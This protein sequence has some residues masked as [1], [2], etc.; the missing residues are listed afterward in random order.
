MIIGTAGHIDHGKTSLVHVLTGVDTDRLKQEKAQGISIELGYAYMPASAGQTIGFID[1]PGHERL[2]HTMAA[3]SSGIDF[4]LLVVAADDGVMP[5]TRE[6]VAILK[7]L[8]VRDGAV[9]ITKRDR[10]DLSRASAVRR[11]VA[12]LVSGTFLEGKPVFE[13]SAVDASHPGIQALRDYLDARVDACLRR[14][15]CGLFRLAIDRVF[16]LQGHGTV[17]TGTVYS[18]S[19]A[20]G[21]ESADLRLM[22]SGQRIRIRS[23]RAQ[24]REVSAATMGQRCALNLPGISTQN[25]ARGDWIADARCFTPSRNVDVRLEVLET[26]DMPIRTWTAV[27]VHLGAAHHVA[28][29]VPLM[30]GA[31]LPRQSAVVQL[32]FQDPVCAMPGDRFIV[33]NAQARQTIAGG[34]VLD[35]NAPDRKR[36]SPAR[37]AWLDG[38]WTLLDRGDWSPLL[39]QA[40]HGLNRALL[41]RLADGAVDYGGPDDALWVGDKEAGRGSTLILRRHWNVLADSVSSALDAYH[42]AATDEPGVD[43][44]RLKRM[45]QPRLANDV[46]TALLDDLIDE[47][48]IVR[49]GPW[50]HL[51]GHEVQLSAAEAVLAQRLLARIHM[52][53]FDP[54]WARDLANEMGYEEDGVRQLLQKLVRR[55]LLFQVVRD[56]F[57]HHEHTVQLARLFAGLAAEQGVRAAEFRDA[58]GLGRKRAIQLLEF[59]GRLGYTRRIRDKH[60]VRSDSTIFDEFRR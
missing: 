51:P 10:V 33:R 56:L 52:G 22:P 47:G 34:V 16:T 29:V 39:E 40:P 18:G 5:Q 32:V 48:R 24:N 11:E 15:D 59:F 45:A 41:A 7:L 1:V 55:G 13:L 53:G 57:Y 38:L 20:L 46:W 9:A 49:N 14:P 6:H 26:A 60:I 23:L 28:H 8:G 21:D 3:G 2:V 25:I 50:L 43:A 37:L 27:H 36:R 19:V 35:P 4:G 42:K 12:S 30:S 31:V 44:A 58:T 54:L 17:V